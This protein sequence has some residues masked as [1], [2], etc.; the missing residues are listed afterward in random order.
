[1]IDKNNFIK[2]IS[3]KLLSLDLRSKRTVLTKNQLKA[4]ESEI[5]AKI[6]GPIKPNERR[7]FFNDNKKSW[8]FHQEI[9]DPAGVV[10]AVTLHYEVHPQG[11]LRISSL[12]GVKNEFIS[13]QELDNFMSA[14]EIYYGRVMREIYHKEPTLSKKSQ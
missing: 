11:I 4:K 9:T 13:G 8:F 6:F 1:M 3:K 12:Q 7:E 14:I 10:H 2:A 5:G